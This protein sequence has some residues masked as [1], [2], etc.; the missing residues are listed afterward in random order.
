MANATLTSTGS[1]QVAIKESGVQGVR[2]SRSQ[3]FKESGVQGVWLRHAY[4]DRLST[5]RSVQVAQYKS[6]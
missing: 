5:S 4:F 6:K 2:S 1:V 3:E